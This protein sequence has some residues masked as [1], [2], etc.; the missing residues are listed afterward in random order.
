M[1]PFL[2]LS[3]SFAIPPSVKATTMEKSSIKD[4]GKKRPVLENHYGPDDCW[5]YDCCLMANPLI[6]SSEQY[7]ASSTLEQQGHTRTP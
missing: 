3:V 2:L 5:V 7:A 1:L 4:W 6:H